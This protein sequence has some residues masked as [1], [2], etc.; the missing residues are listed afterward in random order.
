MKE[1]L[2]RISPVWIKIILFNIKSYLNIRNRYSKNY[3]KYLEEYSKLWKSS[4]EEVL[5]YQKE[6]LS[7]F[8]KECLIYVPFYKDKFDFLGINLEQIDENPLEVIK[9]FPL[10]TKEERKTKVSLLVNTNINRPTIEIS[11]TSGTSGAPTI[12]YLDKESIERSFALWTRFHNNIGLKGREFK[13]VRFSGRLIINPKTIK[14]PFWIYNIFDKQLFMSSYHLKDENLFHYVNKLNSF[15]PDLIDGYPSA[16]YIVSMYINNNNISLNFVP[17][18]IATTAETLFDYQRFEIEKAFA[19]KVFN[20]YASSEGVPPI[21]E[22]ING[23]LHINE[24][25]GFFE[26]L[27]TENLPAKPG[28]IAK[29]VVTSFRNWKTPL[30][31]YNI[32]DSV[33]LPLTQE[34]C[35]CGC[36]MP[37]VDTIVGREDDILWTREKGF[38]GRMHTAYNGLIGIKKSQIIQVSEGEIIVNQSVDEKYNDTINKQLIANLRDRLGENVSIKINILSDVPNGPNGKFNAVIRKFKI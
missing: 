18:A 26:F 32:Q 1:K 8:L 38:V 31:R 21:T 24:D 20:Q 25:T 30:L 9:N 37:Y 35:E 22:C 27:N 13:K 5:D 23:R 4:K 14:P 7:L 28:E 6:Q 19:C 29:L 11:L 12:N 33:L 10:L 15:K 36:N 34:K 3:F 17:K 2:Y 16:L